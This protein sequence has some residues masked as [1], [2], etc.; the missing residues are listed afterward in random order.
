MQPLTWASFRIC[1]CCFNPHPARRPDATPY[2]GGDPVRCD[3]CFNPHPARRPDATGQFGRDR[4][5]GVVSILIQPEGR[6]QRWDPECCQTSDWTAD[7]SILIQPEGRMQ[8]G[9]DR[10]PPLLLG[11][12]T[13]FNPHPARRPDATPSGASFGPGLSRQRRFNPHPARRPDATLWFRH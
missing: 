9:Q 4:P 13:R 3:Q 12:P 1:S 2:A 10:T 6:M 11:V 7:V 8:P 5:G